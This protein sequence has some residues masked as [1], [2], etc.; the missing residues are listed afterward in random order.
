[1]ARL[2]ESLYCY[3]VHDR[4]AFGVLNSDPLHRC[5]QRLLQHRIDVQALHE[6]SSKTE[7]FAA[8]T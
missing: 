3:V 4:L 8:T 7:N 2:A 6:D 1:M 5:G